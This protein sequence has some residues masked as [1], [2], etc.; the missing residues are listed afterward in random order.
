MLL[1]LLG[2]PPAYEP[3]VI[4][5]VPADVSRYLPGLRCE[6]QVVRT[7]ANIPHIYA[8]DRVDLARVMGFVAAQDR[9]FEI[10]LARRLGLGTV[11]EL[12][13]N[14]ALESDM[15]SRSSGMT[16]VA[17]QVLANLTPDQGEW[18]DAY[19]EGIN[20]YIL[21]ASTGAVPPP[22]E[23]ELAGNFLGAEEPTDLMQPFDRRA[24]AGVAAT[25]IYNL[26]YET[27]DVGRART[28]ATL[29][30]LFDGA[31]YAEL[32]QAGVYEDIWWRVA[33]PKLASSSEGG[34]NNQ[35]VGGP[36]GPG[37][38]PSADPHAQRIEIG[39][40]NRATE[41]NDK[42]QQRLGHDWNMGF[43]S[44]AW[45]VAGSAST[46][47]R[48]LMA[49]DGHLALDIPGLFWQV[50]LDTEL[51]GGGD[52]HQLG[53]T[54]PGMP[55]M[56]VGTNGKVAW[57]Q[58]QLMGDITDWYREELTLDADGAPLSTLFK[59]EQ[60]SLASVD[61]TFVVADIPLLDSEGRTETW[62][63]YTTF[64]GRWL[65][66]IEGDVVSADYE[67][68]SGETVV[69]LGGDFV[70]PKDVDGDGIVTALSFDYTGLD[71][72]NMLQALDAF[73]HSDTVQDFR[74]ATLG[75]VAYS[76][77][78]T[79]SDSSGQI[80]Y[81]GYQ[82]VPC[83]EY[84]ERA[85][86][87]SWLPGSN[88]QQVLDGTRYSGFEI[89]TADGWVVE[90]ESDP[91]KCVVPLDVYPQSL[92]PEQGYVFTA[93]N[94]PGNI[95]TDDSL[96]NDPWYI[97]GSWI[98]GYRADRID[99]LLSQAIADDRADL[100][101]MQIIQGDIRSA[102]GAAFGPVLVESIELAQ[103]LASTDGP[104]TETEQRIV[105]LYLQDAERMDEALIYLKAWKDADYPALSGVETFY[106]TP[107]ENEATMS[108]ATT[109]HNAWMGRFQSM[110]FND[111][112]M[113]DV[114]EPTGATGIT[115][116]LTLMVDGRGEDNPADLAAWNEETGESIFFDIKSTE[117]VEVSQE[118]ALMALLDSF[119]WLESAPEDRERGGYGSPDMENWIWGLKH[120]VRFDSILAGFLG[121]DFGFL[122][123]PFSITTDLL[124]LAPDLDRDD[125][126]SDLVGF[127]RHGDTLAV[128]AANNGFS[129]DNFDYGSGPVFRMVVALD[130]DSVEV[131]NVIP[132]G[133]SGLAA[134]PYFADQ[135]EL[136]LGN[137]A[138]NIPF[139]P[140]DVA[141]QGISREVFRPTQADLSCGR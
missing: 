49:G 43:G 28:E 9:Y 76:Q 7:E 78:F 44:N 5:S 1:L 138:L 66:D 58:T 84:L 141:A 107:G 140:E 35:G 125:P 99:T 27:G 114:W 3:P 20:A 100:E 69:M 21:A 22:S 37:G 81:T 137:Q 132:G 123:E 110:V 122:T 13:G 67:A 24:V 38:T 111:E 75:L 64:D 6:A 113:P 70:V 90:G 128:D 12:L 53:L 30:G 31:P 116:A 55:Y 79:V 62:R 39:L 63:R 8:E 88:P 120:V 73:G 65:A 71:N 29:P 121:D 50:G 131:I 32:R 101:E 102:L 108:V 52:T 94:D 68:Q 89:P 87:G 126:R 103:G 74:D 33:P 92:N 93:N 118:I 85:A 54:I 124:P 117:E 40:L 106:H 61:E 104:L 11:S 16:F 42:L 36:P 77:N 119:L 133:Q 25:I 82:A 45:A 96:T 26:G 130:Q 83:R 129:T 95:S 19:A 127:P 17:E 91:Y 109:L 139:S 115:R 51:L 105:D 59:G 80:Y 57:S 97:G 10:D 14:D 47:G 136:W 41:R 56:A 48:S 4:E 2:C 72:A 135:A 86:D 46:D 134:D 23:L 98:E 18:M 112:G 34:W 15:E 60:E